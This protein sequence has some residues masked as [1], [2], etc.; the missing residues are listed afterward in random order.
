[1]SDHEIEDVLIGALDD[2]RAQALPRV[3]PAGARAAVATVRHRRQVRAA[4]LAA[5]VAVAVVIPIAG[6]AGLRHNGGTP[7]A[8]PTLPVSPSASAPQSPSPSATASP[9]VT[10]LPPLG[11]PAASYQLDNATIPVPAWLNDPYCPS[12][13]VKFTKG[14]SGEELPYLAIRHRLDI[15]VDRDGHDEIVL[16]VDCVVGE[17]PE[18]QV[19]AL[20]TAPGHTLVVRGTVLQ[21][22]PD[23]PVIESMSAAGGGDVQLVVADTGRCCGATADQQLQQQR[24][25]HWDG[26]GFS[27]SGGSTSFVI[28]RDGVGVR[29]TGTQ[30]VSGARSTLTVTVENKG[31]HS[32]GPVTVVFVVP[33]GMGGDSGGD[34]SSC[35][36]QAPPAELTLVTCDF[37]ELASGARQ[38]VSLPFKYVAGGARTTFLLR[39]RIGDQRYAEE[40]LQVA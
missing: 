32:V 30:A 8:D 39:L 11:P 20:R 28:P 38:T 17:T 35:D 25:Y 5:V 23:V 15:D 36:H 12:G 26:S 29:L 33:E 27:Q 14:A 31:G 7:P 16:F 1:M 24:R 40:P 4:L 9:S 34:W 21:Y 37:G 13:N 22:S 10:A 2:F 6:F 18:S 19:V 3:K